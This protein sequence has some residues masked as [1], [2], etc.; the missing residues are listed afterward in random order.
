M[1]TIA[2]TT[3]AGVP[4]DPTGGLTLDALMLR[5]KQLAE[6]RGQIA[7]PR[8]IQSPWQGLAQMAQAFV[9]ARQE[10]SVADQIAAGRDALAKIRAGVNL[11]TGPTA[12]Q[13]AQASLYD[14]DYAD[15][16]T[17]MAADFIKEKR[18]REFDIANREDTQQFQSGERVAGEQFTGGQNQLTRDQQTAL[19]EDQQK[20]QAEAAAKAAEVDAAAAAKAADVAAAKPIT[21]SAQAQTDYL[22]GRYGPVGSPEAIAAR[23]AEIKK[24]TALPG[25]GV[26]INTGDTSSQLVKQFDTEEGKSWAGYLAAGAK[27][28]AVM[29]DMQLLDELGKI[30]PQGPVPGYLQKMF[31]GV[32]SAGA[33]FQSVVNRVAPQMRVEGS[34]STSDI[35]YNGMLRS[36]QS[37]SNYPEANRLI[38]G[39]MKA[40]AQ[41][42]LQRADIV[43]RW[44]NGEIKDAEARTA[45]SQLN[46]QSIMSPELQA[47]MSGL[48]PDEAA[49]GGGADPETD[50]LVKKYTTPAQ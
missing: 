14:P 16:L 41:I 19:Q 22:A 11:D 32:D 2:S 38:G 31:P 33:A 18:Q 3:S 23:D 13:I 47:L 25:S 17:Q 49:A 44:R 50:A 36:L 12:E 1:A 34:G 46:R 42:D 43:T 6:Q 28:G 45:L 9:G 39:M 29:N 15:R 5:Q 35:E 37:L 27:A 26:T 48:K 7:A 8:V 10:S 40:K 20:A 24:A 4:T 30:A 21:G